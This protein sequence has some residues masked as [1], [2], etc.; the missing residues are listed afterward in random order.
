VIDTSIPTIVPPLVA[1]GGSDGKAPK[2]PGAGRIGSGPP[3]SDLKKSDLKKPEPALPPKHKVARRQVH[4]P[5]VASAQQ[6]RFAF[7]QGSAVRLR[8]FF[9]RN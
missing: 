3:R 8:F 9:G 1:V 5:M 2:T 4:Q 7:A 6:P